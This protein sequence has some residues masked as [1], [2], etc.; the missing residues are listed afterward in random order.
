MID[1][2]YNEFIKVAI[3]VNKD[4][5]KDAEKF[6]N[7]K[8]DFAERKVRE[9]HNFYVKQRDNAL[10]LKEMGEEDIMMSGEDDNKLNL[11]MMQSL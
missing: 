10:K 4:Y 2:L 5:F 3:D 8:K 11:L 1:H 6:K 9:F 7:V